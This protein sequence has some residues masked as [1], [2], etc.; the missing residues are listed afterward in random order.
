MG[1]MKKINKKL[2]IRMDLKNTS[3]VNR[4]DTNGYY[5]KGNAKINIEIL[6]N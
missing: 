6:T 4:I 2:R 5:N 3:F 1:I